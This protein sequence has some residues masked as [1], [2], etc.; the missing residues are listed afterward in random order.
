MKES[1]SKTKEEKP[2]N[3]KDAAMRVSKNSLIVNLGLSLFKL[4]AG[5]L[6]HS[7]AM[8]SDAVHSASDVFSTLIVMAGIHMANKEADKGHPYGHERLECA[9]ALILAFVLLLTGAGIGYQGIVIIISGQFENLQTPGILALATAI[10]SIVVKE[11][12]YWYTKRV[13]DQINSGA[14][15]AD[16]WHHRSDALS[17]IGALI[18]I[19]GA[20]LGEPLLD[21][22]VSVLICFF[23]IKA[24]VDIFKDALDKMVDKACDDE[25]VEKLRK[26]ILKQQGVMG[27]TLL[28]TRMFGS[29]IY[30]D[31]EIEAD[32]NLTLYE[33]HEIAEKVHHVIEITN[34][35]V[36]HCMVHVNP[37]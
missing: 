21:P 28:Q 35:Q 13:A 32:G 31:V 8:V 22:L 33:S 12:M 14:L 11:W 18:G 23:I 24:A 36:K 9:A 37:K 26:V 29:K 3:E 5:I 2:A 34:H 10:I 25:I 27:I 6:A 20:R 19:A 7:G 30:V 1:K 17:S 4:L 16:A 15:K